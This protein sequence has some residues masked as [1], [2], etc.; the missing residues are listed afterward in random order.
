MVKKVHHRNAII[1]P[2]VQ[3]LTQLHAD[4]ISL[5]LGYACLILADDEAPISSE[6]I[7]TILESAGIVVEPFWPQVF[8]QA[9]QNLDSA[10]ITAMF[11]GSVAAHAT[12]S[13]DTGQSNVKSLMLIELIV[14]ADDEGK[15]EE[16]KVAEQSESSDDSDFGMDLFG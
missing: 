15:V 7:A 16:E 4:D 3:N 5:A 9:L 10:S 6:K 14:A 11:S 8:G 2:A 1:S 13:N 12:A